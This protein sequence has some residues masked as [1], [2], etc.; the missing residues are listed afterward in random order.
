MLALFAAR[1]S[2][3]PN[4][5]IVGLVGAGDVDV[6]AFAFYPDEPLLLSGWMMGD[7]LLRGKAAGLQASYGR[8]DIILFGF[9]VHN[10]AQ[11][12][13]TLKMFFNALLYR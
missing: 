12:R 7:D 13:S 3:P 8:G 1:A 6:E 4:D 11:A 2:W 9:N 10:R 5:L